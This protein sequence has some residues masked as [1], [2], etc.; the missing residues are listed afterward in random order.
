MLVL[1]SQRG[2][3]RAAEAVAKLAVAAT[4]AVAAAPGALLVVVPAPRQPFTVVAFEE[5]R[6][7]VA[8]GHTLP[9]EV[10][11]P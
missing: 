5:H 8:M 11:G 10:L 3:V 1:V 4:L 2:Q 7:S 6:L 9:G